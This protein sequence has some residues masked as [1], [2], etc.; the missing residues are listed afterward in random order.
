MATRLRKM[1]ASQVHTVTTRDKQGAHRLM[2][3]PSQTA[4]KYYMINNLGAM[5][6]QGYSTL[7]RNL[8]LHNT[9]E[10]QV[11]ESPKKTSLNQNQL[12]DI[13]NILAEIIA[14]NAP[15]TVTQTKNMMSESAHLTSLIEDQEM[16][17]KIYKRVNYLHKKQPSDAVQNINEAD[18]SETTSDWVAVTVFQGESTS[19]RRQNWSKEDDEAINSIFS[20]FKKCPAKGMIKHIFA[21][22]QALVEIGSQ[23]SIYRCYNKIKNMFK[24]K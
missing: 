8:Q 20:L 6:T 17:K 14:T 5:A 11:S 21:T 13:S 18:R 19:L 1:H 12:N 23:N 4:E 16:V 2:C 22:N 10:T 15:L 9:V 7:T 24:K 3:H